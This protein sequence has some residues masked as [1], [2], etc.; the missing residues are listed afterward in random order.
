MKRNRNHPGT[1]PLAS[2]SLAPG[3]P[4]TYSSRGEEGE[5]CARSMT[6]LR[7]NK[8]GGGVYRHCS[9]LADVTASVA[10]GAADGAAANG[11]VEA[12]GGAPR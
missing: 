4:C 6:I 5:R 11:A 2:S 7:R 1:L 12:S 9:P 10:I 3:T 8:R